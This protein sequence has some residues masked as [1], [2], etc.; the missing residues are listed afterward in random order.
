[1]AGM[2]ACGSSGTVERVAPGLVLKQPLVFAGDVEASN[3]V[4]NSFSVERQILKRLGHHPN[5]VRYLGSQGDGILLAEASHGNLQTYLEAHAATTTLPQRLD[6]CRQA[7]EALA[8]VHDCGVVHSDFCTSN[9]LV[10]K[11]TPGGARDLLLCDFGGS[12]CEELGL[13]GVSMP[14]GPFYSPV[15]D[16]ESCVLLDLFG[17]GSTMYTILTGFWPH[18]DTPGRFATDEE[19]L[20]WE[21]QVAYPNFEDERYPEVGHLLLGDVIL[22]CW[23]REFDTAQEV[24]VALK[25]AMLDHQRKAG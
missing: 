8:Y 20:A 16:D 7:A 21:E 13:D 3:R 17:L 1:M 6:W 15:F 12:V 24:V 10:H 18:K 19:R 25:E 5:I 23:T 11:T 4:A 2:L 22:K 14:D 9:L